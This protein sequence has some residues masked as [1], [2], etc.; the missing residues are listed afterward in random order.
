MLLP[1]AHACFADH[2]RFQLN[3]RTVLAFPNA[4]AT[5]TQA[6]AKCWAEGGELVGAYTSAE[7]SAL[8]DA[9]ST[10]SAQTAWIGL[11]S[12]DGS[13]TAV[14]SN[15]VWLTTRQTPSY[16]MWAPD[17]PNNGRSV[18][19]VCGQMALRPILSGWTP[20]NW[21]DDRC[22]L[23]KA[24]ACEIG[25]Y[26]QREDG[27]PTSMQWVGTS[28]VI[29]A[30]DMGTHRD[31]TQVRSLCNIVCLRCCCAPLLLQ[32]P[33]SV[34]STRAPTLPT[35]RDSAT[36]SWAACDTA[37]LVKQPIVGTQQLPSAQ[38][39]SVAVA[40]MEASAG[41]HLVL[42]SAASCLP[43][44]GECV[45]WPMRPLCACCFFVQPVR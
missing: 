21:D 34:P 8:V 13:P 44:D 39:R 41:R 31:P 37:A 38:V 32:S 29:R 1:C 23:S 3:G 20:G 27:Q 18:Q 36:L 16:S 45:T 30:G 12:A 9:F 33:M 6:Q 14:P 11:R 26:L 17:E 2:F 25:A 19:G 15:Y 42:C 24:F 7:N 4:A 10:Y 28:A 22:E 43:V 35:P 5:Y 40:M